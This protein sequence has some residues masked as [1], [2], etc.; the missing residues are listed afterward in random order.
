MV[1]YD[2]FFNEI[3]EVRVGIADQDVDR[4][5]NPFVIIATPV[6]QSDTNA[7]SPVFKLSAIF[8]NRAKINDSWLT[9][10]SVINGLRVIAIKQGSV[11]LGSENRAIELFLREKNENSIITIN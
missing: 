1:E 4:I 11:V 7:S 8:E 6:I 2:R 3:G 5:A 10:G 9:Q